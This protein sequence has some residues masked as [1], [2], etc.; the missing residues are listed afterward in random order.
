MRQTPRSGRAVTALSL[1]ALLIAAL[2]GLMSMS[3]VWSLVHQQLT[4]SNQLLIKLA[5]RDFVLGDLN[6]GLVAL[7][8]YSRAFAGI[9]LHTFLAGMGLTLCTLQFIPSLRR[10]WPKVHRVIGLFAALAVVGGMAGAMAYLYVTPAHDVFSGEPFEAALWVQAMTTLFALGMAIQAIRARQVR[11]HMG[12]MALLFASLLTAPLLRIEFAIAGNWLPYN[13]AQ[14]NAGLAVILF[15]QAVLIMSWWMQH[16]GRHD[17]PLLPPQ[18][19][20]PLPALRVLAWLGVATALHEGLLAPL[21][22]DLIA[23]WRS[24][25]ERLPLIAACWAVSTSLLLPR[26]VHE[27]PAILQGRALRYSTLVLMALAATGAMLIGRQLPD[28]D[29][30]QIGRLFFWMGLGVLGWGLSLAGLIWRQEGTTLTP[31]RILSVMSWFTPAMWLPMALSLAFTGWSSSAIHTSTL[32]LSLG[33]FAWHGFVS[34]FGLPMPGVPA[35]SGQ[36]HSA[37]A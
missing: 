7:R 4:L 20:L 9:S 1:L 29:Y 21:G 26:L 13:I 8:N 16:I 3:H 27:L 18:L 10:R 11:I 30:H 17:V 19:S 36:P 34:A 37:V 31:W 33:L 22:L 14:A 25:A 28:Q 35:S 15:P 12:W 24:P 6:V 32:T 23:T 5:S 2:Y